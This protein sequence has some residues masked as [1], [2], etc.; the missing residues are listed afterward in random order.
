[1]K[2]VHIHIGESV[3]T[4]VWSMQQLKKKM[5]IQ[6]LTLE[7]ECPITYSKPSGTKGVKEV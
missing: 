5:K 1:M 7:S 2:L 3:H 6:N 4:W